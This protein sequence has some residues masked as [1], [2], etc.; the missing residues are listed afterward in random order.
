MKQ[1]SPARLLRTLLT[2]LLASAICCI[3][4]PSCGTIRTHAGIEHE[5]EY[6]FDG[7]GHHDRG[8]HHGHHKKP[9][10]HKHHHHHHDD[11]AVRPFGEE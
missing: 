4:L 7:H 6:D 5:Y 3:C 2:G 9:K 11:D 1:T 10:K 8:R